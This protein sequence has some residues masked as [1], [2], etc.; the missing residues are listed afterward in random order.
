MKYP[1]LSKQS[2]ITESF[3]IINKSS[4]NLSLNDLP[5]FKS[6]LLLQGPVGNFFFRF[7]QFLRSK[8]CLVKKINFNGGDDYFYPDHFNDV[9]R[10]QFKINYFSVF[11]ENF[12]KT[13]AFD[14]VFL[15][16]DCRPI[17]KDTI[18]I[19]KKY[20]VKVYVFEEGYFRP[21]HITLEENGVNFNSRISNYSFEDIQNMNLDRFNDQSLTFT[22]KNTFRNIAPLA[23]K[24]WFYSVLNSSNYPNYDHHRS[25]DL[26]IGFNWIVGAV[27]FY[28]HSITELNTRKKIYRI[29]KSKNKI[30]FFPLQLADDPQITVHSNYKNIEKYIESVLTSF[31]KNLNINTYLIIKNHPMGIGSQNYKRLILDLANTLDISNHVIYINNMRFEKISKN[32]T[33]C[34]TVNSTFGL[35]CLLLNIPVIT[36]GKCFFDKK[37]LTFQGSIDEFLNDPGSTENDSVEQFCSF[38][39][40]QSQINGSFY[41]PSYALVKPE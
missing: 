40:T 8:N 19:F 17:H 6:V 30:Y 39:H 41:D 5:Q 34:I 18:P 9:L 11:I 7:A 32:V 28:M 21:N 33:G 27:R 24:Y 13:N 29:A 26:K 36:L 22:S 15:F 35:K 14:A 23:I 37:H 3:Q 2:I 25:L 4:R 31:A 10:Y 38:L 16:G 1:A 20:G 12:L